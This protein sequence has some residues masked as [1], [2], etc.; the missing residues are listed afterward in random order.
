MV[1]TFEIAPP[2][3]LTP[4]VE[5]TGPL[6]RIIWAWFSVACISGKFGDVWDAFRMEER[7]KCWDEINEAI[8]TGPLPGNGWDRTAERNGLVLASNIIMAGIK[9]SNAKL[10]GLAPQKGD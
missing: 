10:T 3:R 9:G 8:K 4:K 6:T 5:K 1:V 7:H 2:F